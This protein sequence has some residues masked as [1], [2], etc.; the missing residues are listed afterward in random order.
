MVSR[1]Y[2]VD[3]ESVPSRYTCEWKTHLPT[4]LNAEIKKRGLDSEFEV[5][6]VSGGE[7]S[8]EATPG[9]FLNFQQTNI[10]KNNQIN[11]IARRFTTDVKPGDQFVFADAWHPGV[12]N[13]KYM[14]ELLGIPVKIHGLWH[15]GSYD[16]QDFLG[17]LVGNKPWVRHAEKSF[18]GCFDHNYF[19]TDF[20]A[21]I[22]MEELLN[23]GLM[24]E[25]PW[26]EED[27]E[28]R[29]ESGKMVKTGWPMEYMP[30]ILKPYENTKKENIVIFPHRVAPEKQP[31]IFR[32]LAKALPQYEFV[33]CQDRKL[34]KAD[35]HKLLAKSKI[36][37]SAN[38]QETLG[39]SPFE[40][41]LLGVYPL[42]PDRLSYSEM[43]NKKYLYPSHWTTSFEDYLEHKDGIVDMIVDVMEHHDDLVWEV[44]E[45]LA[46]HLLKG[47]FSASNL[48][49]QLLRR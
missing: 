31:E 5:I 25:N 34:Q 36:M 39:I 30:N 21:R 38:L 17:R 10:Y 35:Y 20:H 46:P 9:A 11:E 22:F 37:W 40:G 4:L 32:D 7:D 47:Y 6:N 45:E 49:E 13:L 12:I 41:A 2:I 15:A 1:I 29:Y 16:P 44:K 33:V 27:W 24:A 14:S 23:D 42:L 8:I 19:A 43:Y 3:L 28:E 26:F 18:Y 48:V